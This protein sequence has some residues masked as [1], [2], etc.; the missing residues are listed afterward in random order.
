MRT[1]TFIQNFDGKVYNLSR[2]SVPHLLH[3]DALDELPRH[4]EKAK[5]RIVDLRDYVVLKINWQ[6]Y[7]S[8]AQLDPNGIS[9]LAIR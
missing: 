5:P 2:A 9:Y 3:W 7:L 1:N 4:S 6:T 8:S